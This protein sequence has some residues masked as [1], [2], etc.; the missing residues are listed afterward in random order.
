MSTRGRQ[1]PCALE[2]TGRS[3]SAVMSLAVVSI[4]ALVLAVV[5][6]FTT[7]INVGVVAMTLAWLIGVYLN[8]MSVDAVLEG[9]PTALMV[10]LIG[11]TLLFSMAECNGT[12]ARLTARSVRLCRGHA[13]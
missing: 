10:T 6:S 2:T 1:R 7:A 13:G 11:I 5:L 4:A 8:G 3:P 9:F 12:L